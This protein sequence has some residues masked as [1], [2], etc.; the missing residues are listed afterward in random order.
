ME[1]LIKKI[2]KVFVFLAGLSLISLMFLI[3]AGVITRYIFGFSIPTSYEIVEQYLMP[4]TIF[5]ALGYSYKSGI[6]PRIDS[7]VEKVKS[8]KTRKIINVSIL[9][10]ETL[11]F[12]YITYNMFSFAFYSFDTGMGFRSNGINFQLYGVHFITAVSFLWVTVIMIHQCYKGFI[13]KDVDVL[14]KSEEKN[15]I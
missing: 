11:L 12:I 15:V 7:F 10:I 9:V 2:N 3:T 14:E 1:S 5:L 4:L 8:Y 13:D 6:F